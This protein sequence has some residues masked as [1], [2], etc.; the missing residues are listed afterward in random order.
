MYLLGVSSAELLELYRERYLARRAD[1]LFEFTDESGT[2]CLIEYSRGDG[3]RFV[4]FEGYLLQRISGSIELLEDALEIA[5]AS[6]TARG[7][8]F[9][10][11]WAVSLRNTSFEFR[12]IVERARAVADEWPIYSLTV[13]F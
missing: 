2:G 9:Y 8:V 3:H 12:E 11:P 10:E 6:L 13:A 1:A 5:A 7:S 4:Y